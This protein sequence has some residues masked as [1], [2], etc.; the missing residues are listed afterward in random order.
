M[1]FCFPGVAPIGITELLQLL[2][3]FEPRLGFILSR[4][5]FF[6]EMKLFPLVPPAGSIPFAPIL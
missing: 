5:I 6:V 4:E 3:S 2:A 1:L